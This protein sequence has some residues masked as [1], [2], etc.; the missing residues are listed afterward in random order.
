[1][2]VWLELI[3]L[4]TGVRTDQYAADVRAVAYTTMSRVARNL[5]AIIERLREIGYEFEV[6]SGDQTN[7]I[8]FGAARRNL[9]T[10][11]PTSERGMP[12][13][14]PERRLADMIRLQQDAGPFSVSLR[15]W[16]EIVGSVTL[17]GRHPIL[18]PGDGKL[19]SDPL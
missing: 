16:F 13:M 3:A 15:A 17:L 12:L 2:Q 4:G 9:W 1:R 18:S 11:T 6:E 8:P 19:R 5:A 10:G 7:V 14:P